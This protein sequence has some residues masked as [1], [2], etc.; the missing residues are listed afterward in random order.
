MKA[1]SRRCKTCRKKVPAESAFTSQLRAFCSYECLSEFTQ[2]ERGSLVIAKT[3]KKDIQE[4]KKKLLTRSDYMKLAQAAFNAYI[5]HRDDN[6]ACISCG[7]WILADQPGGGWDAGHYRSTGSAQHLRVGGL[8]AA[9]NCHKQCVKCNR[10]LSGNVAEYRKGLIRK[11]G[12]DL[13]EK[14]E[15]DQGSRNYSIEDLQR[16]TNIYRKRK[17]LHGKIRIRKRMQTL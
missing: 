14:I 11:I 1:S 10:F 4:R 12:L 2:S 15:A 3:R 17:K 9:L 6:D 16:I 13:V 5:R 7:N 8:M